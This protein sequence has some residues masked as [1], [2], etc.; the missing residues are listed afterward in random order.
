MAAL[1]TGL[2]ALGAVLVQLGVLA[3]CVAGVR[4]LLVDPLAAVLDLGE[5][6]ASMWRRLGVL[7][8]LVAGYVLVVRY[9]ERRAAA[10]LRADLRVCT[11]AAV[12]GAAMIGLTIVVL[13]ATGHHQVVETR[14]WSGTPLVA[15]GI[16]AAAAVEEFVFRGVLFR[17][18][19]R[20]AGT[21]VALVAIS[22]AFGAVH[23]QNDGATAMTILSVTLLGMLWTGIFVVTRNLW[24]CTLHHAAWNFTI[25]STGLP[26]S[27]LESWRDSAPLRSVAS[28]P[29]WWTGGAFGPEDSILN[30]GIVALAVALVLFHARRRGQLRKRG[31][32]RPVP[33]RNRVPEPG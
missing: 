23:L 7:G 12:S 21:I 30:V 32:G 29:G 19:E 8:A 26:L 33:G 4:F 27:G 18:L 17:A 25:F 20:G 6:S 31:A 1:V 3:A 22:T 9:Q 16:L 2:R 15:A 14:D 11:L 24:A 28:G 10:E 13:Y 5:S